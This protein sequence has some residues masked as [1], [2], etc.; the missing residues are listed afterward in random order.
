MQRSISGRRVMRKAW[1]KRDSI[2]CA[3]ER[4]ASVK[5]VAAPHFPN[6]GGQPGLL[7]ISRCYPTKTSTPFRR[8]KTLVLPTTDQP[9]EEEAT[10]KPPQDL[11]NITEVNLHCPSQQ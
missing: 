1:Q 8:R 7:E 4:S 6:P 3:E 5:D 9:K 2:G 11:N 10:K